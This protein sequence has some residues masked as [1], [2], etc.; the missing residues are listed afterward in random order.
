MVDGPFLLFIWIKSDGEEV[1]E[2][3]KTDNDIFLM[4]IFF[5]RIGKKSLQV[6]V[7]FDS[8]HGSKNSA[9]YKQKKHLKGNF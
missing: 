7:Q 9:D 2:H 1:S 4:D 6:F 8:I 3:Y 5:R